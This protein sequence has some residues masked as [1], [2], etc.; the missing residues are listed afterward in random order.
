MIVVIV[1]L[2]TESCQCTTVSRSSES[3]TEVPADIP[4][5]VEVLDLSRNGIKALRDCEFCPYTQLWRLDL[6][7]NPISVISSSAFQH[8]VVQNLYLSGNKL[9]VVPDIHFIAGTLRRLQMS[10]NKIRYVSSTAFAESTA[11]R[12]LQLSNNPLTTVCR[13]STE[14]LQNLDLGTSLV[15]DSRLLWI[16]DAADRGVTV[17]DFRCTDPRSLRNRDFSNLTR[18]E[19]DPTGKLQHVH[20]ADKELMP[21]FHVM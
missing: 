15:C 2:C 20:D 7:F 18:E 4:T 13:I 3:L 8:T 11:L 14:T 17:R 5:N 12:V 9:V 1:C 16:K 21:G 6:M 19:L 10:G